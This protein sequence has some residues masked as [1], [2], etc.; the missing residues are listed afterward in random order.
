MLAAEEEKLWNKL[1]VERDRHK[2][3]HAYDII[4]NRAPEKDHMIQDLE[5]RGETIAF[6]KV[7]VHYIEWM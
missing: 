3:S 2:R 6:T 4:I 7:S 1:I 5:A